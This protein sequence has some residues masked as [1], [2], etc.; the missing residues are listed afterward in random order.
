[1]ELIGVV[2]V[3]VFQMISPLSDTS[4]AQ[5][6]FSMQ[7]FPAHPEILSLRIADTSPNLPHSHNEI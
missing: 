6:V 3:P 4:N 1:M 7:E 5:S 2:S